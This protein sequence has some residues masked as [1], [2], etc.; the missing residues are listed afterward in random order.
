[1]DGPQER[2]LPISA[3]GSLTLINTQ[4]FASKKTYLIHIISPLTG[5]GNLPKSYAIDDSR[6]TASGTWA[7]QVETS[8]YRLNDL[9][10]GH[11]K[12]FLTWKRTQG[13]STN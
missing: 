5:T 8:P 13:E 3:A 9:I 6:M 11:Q 12:A 10:E 1:M 7:A 2:E 4:L